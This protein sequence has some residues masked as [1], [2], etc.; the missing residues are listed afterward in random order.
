MRNPLSAIL[1]SADGVIAYIKEARR[2]SSGGIN[3]QPAIVEAIMEAAQTIN[4]CGLHQKRIVDDIL[5]MSKLDSN[6]IALS[7]DRVRPLKLAKQALKMYESEIEAANIDAAVC[8]DQSFTN[9]NVDE[10]ILDP[11]RL[12][13]VLINLI[14]NA[15]KVSSEM[16]HVSSISF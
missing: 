3:L 13:Q 9:M 4:L 6:M 1:Q 5:T 10:V 14:T 16:N 12:L 7:P 8:V 11:S 2:L 15:I